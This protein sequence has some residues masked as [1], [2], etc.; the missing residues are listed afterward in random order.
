MDGQNSVYDPQKIF[1]GIVSMIIIMLAL[2]I[3]SPFWLELKSSAKSKQK[4]DP[5]Q[6]IDL[7]LPKVTKRSVTF[8]NNL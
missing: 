2:V 7:K 1:Y 8:R 5:T 6:I 3:M 4:E